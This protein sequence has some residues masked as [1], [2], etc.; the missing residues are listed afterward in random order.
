[1]ALQLAGRRVALAVGI[2]VL[3][4]GTV[5]AISLVK[6]RGESVRHDEITKVADERLKEIESEG[7]PLAQNGSQDTKT[8]DEQK[9]KEGASSDNPGTSSEVA[10][11]PP[12][13]ETVAGLPQTGPADIF[14]L[15]PVGVMTFALVAYIQSRRTLL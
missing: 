12:E 15:L 10:A 8:K 1:M 5:V 7:A 11:N 2:I 14:A 4:I 6:Q 9:D 13:P 3:A